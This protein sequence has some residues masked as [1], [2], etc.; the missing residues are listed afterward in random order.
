MDAEGAEKVLSGGRS[1]FQSGKNELQRRRRDEEWT[2]H[3]G[4]AGSAA[5]KVREREKECLAREV[6]AL[7]PRPA[8]S[9]SPANQRS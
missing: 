6:L 5:G 8:R 4:A 7:L 2:G 1:G 9:G 3:W